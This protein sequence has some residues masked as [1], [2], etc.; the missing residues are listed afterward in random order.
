MCFPIGRRWPN[1]DSSSKAWTL[2]P[3]P[4]FNLDQGSFWTSRLKVR[5]PVRGT[6]YYEE[7]A[8]QILG[9]IT[10]F[11][12]TAKTHYSVRVKSPGVL[13]ALEPQN[14]PSV[15]I[16]RVLSYYDLRLDLHGKVCQCGFGPPLSSLKVLISLTRI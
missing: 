1:S 14:P 3:L 5:L 4:R 11:V 13:K 16:L 12:H 6:G 10:Q 9:G 15:Q 8:K 2:L 7:G